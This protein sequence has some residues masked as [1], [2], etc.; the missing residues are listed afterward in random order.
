VELIS[1]FGH[2]QRNDSF[3]MLNQGYFPSGL[4]VFPTTTEGASHYD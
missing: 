1:L 4:R 2:E 3:T